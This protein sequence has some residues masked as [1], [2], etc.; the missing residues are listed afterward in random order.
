MSVNLEYSGKKINYISVFIRY[1][2]AALLIY[3]L[4]SN[5]K[6]D[7]NNIRITADNFIYYLLSFLFILSAELLAVLRLKFI[8]LIANTHVSFVDLLKLNLIGYGFSLFL[9]GA[10]TGDLV[11][12]VYLGKQT[13]SKIKAFVCIIADR[14]LGLMGLLT[15]C[16]AAIL[17][18]WDSVHNVKGMYILAV[19]L[20]VSVSAL[21]LSTMIYL[22]ISKNKF[23]FTMQWLNKFLIFTHNTKYTWMLYLVVMICPILLSMAFF[24]IGQ[25]LSINASFLQYSFATPL[26]LLSIA[27][28]LTPGGVGVG[29]VAA[30]KIF[31]W[32][33]INGLASAA[34]MVTIF[35]LIFLLFSLV[36]IVVFL[37]NPKLKKK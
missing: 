17:L 28:P 26:I 33:G 32:V 15:L 12:L 11:K 7:F 25:I 22:M 23:N 16:G 13:N 3:W 8:L 19:G 21:H 36:G 37:V 14:A 35:Q 24:F 20:V 34:D 9:P 5:D 27:I 6:I 30:D 29:Q 2:V 4:I 18:N 10:L 31:S 1:L